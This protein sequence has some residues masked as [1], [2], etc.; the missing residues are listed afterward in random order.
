MNGT[1][2]LLI[3]VALVLVLVY[4][5]IS[6]LKPLP[7]FKHRGQSLV[8]VFCVLVLLVLLG[9]TVSL[10][11]APTEV[12][13]QA[14]QA[15]EIKCDLFEIK[16]KLQNDELLVSLNT[17]CPDYTGIMISV[18]RKYNEVG[19]PDA[20]SRYYFEES[21]TVGNWRR[22]RRISVTHAEWLAEL[23]TFQRTMNRLGVGFTVDSISDDIEIRMVVHVN[24]KNVRF[25]DRNSNLVGKAVNT[26]GLRIIDD[27]VSVNYPL[28][29]TSGVKA[30]LP[31]LD[32]N[33]LDRNQSY[34]ISRQTPLMSELN[35]ADPLAAIAKTKYLSSGSI[36]RIMSISKKL[37]IPWYKVAV[38]NSS[39]SYVGTGWI[40]STALLGQNL[41]PLP[42]KNDAEDAANNPQPIP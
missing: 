25:G 15:E 30:V 11:T 41:E 22:Q 10:S 32:P 1:V 18:D 34:R 12:E 36:I 42:P 29:G 20:Y 6:M 14:T 27:E 26:T 39:G 16:S 5:V 33:S 19:N 38:S 17:D 2:V 9:F 3:G 40:N 13:S 24:Q 21:S 37:G 4:S 31:S 23:K 35:P 7:P 28:Q 8:G